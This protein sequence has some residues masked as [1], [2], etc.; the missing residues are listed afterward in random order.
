MNEINKSSEKICE[1]ISSCFSCKKVSPLEMR[2]DND[3]FFILCEL[4]KETLPIT[5]EAA[6]NWIPMC[7]QLPDNKTSLLLYKRFVDDLT[8]NL[9]TIKANNIN[10]KT[11]IANMVSTLEKE[12]YPTTGVNFVS[13]IFSEEIKKGSFNHLFI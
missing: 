12:G 9:A 10:P 4:C 3:T 2:K 5:K 13:N 6:E 11:F 1:M 8:N 7:K